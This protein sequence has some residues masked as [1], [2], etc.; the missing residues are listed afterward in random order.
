M[1]QSL[2]K[3]SPGPG[4]VLAYGRGVVSTAIVQD[5]DGRRDLRSPTKAPHV[6]L[7]EGKVW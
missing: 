1:D 2:T 6:H 5:G 3:D 7:I 4:E